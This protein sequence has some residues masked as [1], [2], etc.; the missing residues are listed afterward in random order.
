MNDYDSLPLD[1]V[2]PPSEQLL[3]KL[4][5]LE[6]YDFSPVNW[7]LTTRFGWSE[8]RTMAVERSTKRFLALGL[9]EP[10]THHCPVEEEDEYWHA[11]IINTPWYFEFCDCIF[12]RYYHHTPDLDFG[13]NRVMM[14][15]SLAAR[16][17]WFNDVGRRARCSRCRVG[18]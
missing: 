7:V 15:R 10:E 6:R 5:Q 12:D 9:L 1:L 11:M 17:I 3:P 18:D 8:D 4:L 16:A 13:A 2:R 14:D